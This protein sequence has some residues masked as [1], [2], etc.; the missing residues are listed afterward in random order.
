[1]FSVVTPFFKE[2]TD[3]KQIRYL[4]CIVNP[5]TRQFAVLKLALCLPQLGSS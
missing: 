2:S 1:M 5:L 3:Y 4:A